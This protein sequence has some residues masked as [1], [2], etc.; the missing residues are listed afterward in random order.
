MSYTAVV[1][2]NPT[3][4]AD[5]NQIINA[6]NGTAN[7]TI[8]MQNTGANIISAR[9]TSTPGA[10]TVTLRTLVSGNTATPAGLYIRSDGYGG[11][12]LGNATGQ[13]AHLY[14]STGG[15]TLAENFTVGGNLV[16]AGTGS[17]AGGN[18]TWDNTGTI[19]TLPTYPFPANTQLGISAAQSVATSGLGGASAAAGVLN[20][21][22]GGYA[23]IAGQQHASMRWN[24]YD[25]GTNTVYMSTGAAAY[26]YINGVNTPTFNTFASGT[27]GSPVTGSR[28]MNVPLF[29]TNGGGN[30][31]FRI[32]VG[33]TDPASSGLV[34]DGDLWIQG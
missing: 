26:F 33:T 3:A 20:T 4:S 29:D 12:I 25:N 11:L 2:G 19:T 15:A 10:D 34:H 7:N 9:L 13:V 8:I 32:W 21:A 27:A 14:G 18:I 17:L 5:I 31:G 22:T 23:T 6:L 1:T 24:M 16:I 30:V 28:G